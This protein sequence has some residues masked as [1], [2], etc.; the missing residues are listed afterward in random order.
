MNHL[1]LNNTP[2]QCAME[3]FFLHTSNAMEYL[4]YILPHPRAPELLGGIYLLIM[5][6]HFA[7]IYSRL[8]QCEKYWNDI[9]QKA[10]L[11]CSRDIQQSPSYGNI[12]RLSYVHHKLPSDGVSSATLVSALVLSQIRCCLAP[13]RNSQQNLG[14]I[15]IEL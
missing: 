8:R 1:C 14:E 4:H 6:S 13:Y 10:I 15:P 9:R 7:T 12:G 11:E 2:A 5:F 3:Y